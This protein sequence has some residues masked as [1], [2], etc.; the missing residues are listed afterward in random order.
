MEFHHVYQLPLE[1]F[2]F[3]S[4]KMGLTLVWKHDASSESSSYD[5]LQ[6]LEK[7]RIARTSHEDLLKDDSTEF[8]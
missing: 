2:I 8:P 4:E 3:D 1:K 5:N 6:A 7:L